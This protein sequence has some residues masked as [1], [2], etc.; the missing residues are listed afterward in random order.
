MSNAINKVSYGLYVLTT[1]FDGIDNGCIINTVM[2]VASN[3]ERICISVNNS[4][5]TC[6]LLKKSKKFNVSVLTENTPFD[7]FKNFGFNSGRNYDKFQNKEGIFRSE[8]DVY[9]ISKYSNAYISAKI[10]DMIDMGSHTLFIAETT[11]SY[12][13]ND[14]PSITYSYYH[15]NTKPKPENKSKKGYGCEICGYVY[16]GD[17]LPDDF[18][19][20][21]CKHGVNDFVEIN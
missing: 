14:E 13:F 21:I 3:P 12:A 11:A 10:T 4:N 19:C 8:N 1:A 9:V 15:A 6:E 18:I 7:V 5:Y 17:T 2:Q 16:E 20:P